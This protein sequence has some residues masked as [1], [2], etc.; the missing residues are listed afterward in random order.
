[1]FHEM[2]TSERLD[3]E[4]KIWVILDPKSGMPLG[5]Q[6]DKTMAIM[7]WSARDGATAWQKQDKA[8]RKGH[9]LPWTIARLAQWCKANDCLEIIPD[10]ISKQ[11]KVTLTLSAV[12][13]YAALDRA[14]ADDN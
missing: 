9:V 3:P 8:A 4:W 10:R 7:A 11:S 1:M 5:G 14:A 12:T 2:L 6:V 13:L